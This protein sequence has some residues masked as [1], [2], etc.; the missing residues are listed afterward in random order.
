[1]KA[2][3][4]SPYRSHP[5][6]QTHGPIAPLRDVMRLLITLSQHGLPFVLSVHD[7]AR[8]ARCVWSPLIHGDLIRSINAHHGREWPERDALDWCLGCLATE[9]F[10]TLI[11]AESIPRA[12][13]YGRNG[14]D[15]ERE[16]AEALGLRIVTDVEIVHAHGDTLSA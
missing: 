2:F 12:K 10:D 11:V 13:N 15:A 14:M 3:L 8:S 1:M 4:S 16:L 9:G 7:V 5:C 6:Y